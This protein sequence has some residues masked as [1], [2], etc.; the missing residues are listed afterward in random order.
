M[1]ALIA[2]VTTLTFVTG[3]PQLSAGNS[4][5][6]PSKSPKEYQAFVQEMRS[7]KA[8]VPVVKSPPNLG[9]N[10]RYG[11]DFVV[12]GKNRGWI[13]DGDDVHGWVLY[14]DLK[15]DGDLSTAKPH[16]FNRVSGA[17]SLQITATDGNAE[18]IVRFELKQI[19]VNGVEI[20][21]VSIQGENVRRGVMTIGGKRI[22]FVL[23][24]MSGRYDDPYN[25]LTIDT[26]GEGTLDRYVVA[27]KY[28]NLF[29]KSY[30][31]KV[32]PLG[33]SLA[34]TELA[35][36]MPGRPSLAIGS[37]APDFSAVD[38]DGVT[39]SL[40]QYRGR[41]VLLEFWSTYCG[42]CRRD[43][44]KIVKIY[45]STQRVKLEYLSVSEDDSEATLR[46]FL[47]QFGIK[48]PEICETWEGPVHR[49]Y[50]V[51]GIPTYFLIGPARQILDTWVGADEV[52]ARVSKVIAQKY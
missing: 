39:R 31:F 5:P 37:L 49:L 8:L 29:G 51:N 24:G 25:S 28:M 21:G 17:F 47:T 23:T 50:R 19:D 27:D 52:V 2:F 9:P 14:L 41:L 11:F 10:A 15:G 12:G 32:D 7:F 44:P 43:A 16:P 42:P 4:P 1:N 46:S 30:G 35:V 20:P 26:T 22:P 6:I 48:W 34:L 45:N 3:P 40:A 38:I 36:A 33:A 13:V 18:F